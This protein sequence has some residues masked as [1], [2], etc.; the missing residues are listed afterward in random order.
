MILNNKDFR[1]CDGNKPTNYETQTLGATIKSF[2]MIA[3]PYWKTKESIFAWMQ[4]CGIG[5]FVFLTIKLATLF[6]D[7]YK[8]FWDY[9]QEYN[10]DGFIGG[11]FLFTFL[12]TCHVVVTVYKSYI[13]SALSI[14]WRKWLNE[15]YLKRYLKNGAFYSLQLTD[16]QTDNPDQRIA[17]DLSSFVTLTISITINIVTSVCML[18]AFSKILWGLSS[19]VDMNLGSTTLHL[20]D[21]Y[22]F[23]LALIYSIV[24]TII[25]FLIGKPLTL[26]NFRQQRFEA[27]YRYSLVRL[28]ENAESVALYKGEPEEHKRLSY[29]FKDVVRNYVF[30]IKKTKSLNFF[31]FGCAQTAVI[32][33]IL[34]ASPLYF[35]KILTIGSLMQINSA[36][37]RVYDSMSTLMD[38]FPQLASWKAVV[39]RLALFEK[40]IV[41]TQSLSKPNI[42]YGSDKLEISKLTVTKPNGDI[43]VNELSL[44]LSMG[45][46]LL[47]KGDSGRGKSTLLRS[48]AGVWPY[49][50]GNIAMP[51]PKD[52]L[53]LS[54]RTYMPLGPL[55]DAI[56]YPMSREDIISKNGIRD[57]DNLLVEML[58]FVG[59]DYLV[60]KLDVIDQWSNVLSLGEQQR[61]AFLRAYFNKPKLLFMDEV[62]SALDEPNEARLY[63]KLQDHLS[64]SIIISVGHR[65]TL[66]KY[67]KKIININD[68]YLR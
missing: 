5:I 13:I 65:S 33:P 40:S 11:L 12:A 3:C 26:L 45:E 28:R 39:D 55:K 64:D 58:S 38:I 36:F 1:R 67:H 46:S 15:Y 60:S 57:F 9:I 24:G 20:P 53:F 32:F 63:K 4:V 56:C 6:N 47:I 62:T 52:I 7:W 2:F 19:S 61:I 16:V 10:L 44:S 14:R 34:V 29:L 43:L 59:L 49:A 25:T 35:A 22:L 8:E 42:E 23:Y 17:E 18:V 68:N 48:I 54:Q 66:D 21:G 30:L 31:V 41:N 27:D 50:H 37:S 51:L